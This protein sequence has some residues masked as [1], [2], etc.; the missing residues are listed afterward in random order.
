M[1]TTSAAGYEKINPFCLV[2]PYKIDG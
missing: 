1:K 2:L